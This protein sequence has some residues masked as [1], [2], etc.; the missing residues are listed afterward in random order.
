MKVNNLMHGLTRTIFPILLI[1]SLISCRK[2]RGNDTPDPA[3]Q[4]TFERLADIGSL[5]NSYSL[6]GGVYT[7]RFET[8]EIRIPAEEITQVQD[9]QDKWKTLVTL[10]GGKVVTVPTKGGNLDFMVEGVTLNPSGCNP[11]A[12]LAELRLPAAGRIRV[13]VAGKEGTSG[14]ITHLLQSTLVRQDVP[15]LGLYANY[16]NTITLTY[17]DKDG[18]ER[19]TTQLRIQTAPLPVQGFAIP[20]TIVAQTAKM[21]PGLNLVNYPGESEIDVSAPYMVDA[22]GEIRWILLLKNAPDFQRFG[23]SI[24]LKRTKKGTFISGDGQQHRIVEMD[25]F[26]KLLRKW[27]LAALGYTFHHEVAE[28]QNGNFLVTVSKS[29]ARLANGKPRINDFIIELDPVNGTIAH[30]WDLATML[31]TSRYP[32]LTDGSTPGPFAQSPGNWAHN[33]SVAEHLGNLLITCRYQGVFS[34]TAGG[35]LK[36]IIS[37]HKNW[38]D[39]FRRFLL[40]PVDEAGNAVTDVAVV[41]GAAAAPG[42]DWAWGPHTPVSLPNGNILVFDNGYDRQFT[43]NSQTQNYSRAVEYK[44]DEAKGTVQ[45][46][47]SYGKN[48]GAAAFS[49]ALSGVQYLKQTGHVMFFP[50][51]GVPTAKG[52]GGRVVEVDPATKEVIFEMEITAPSGTAFH[53]VTRLSLYPDTY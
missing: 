23:A 38:G 49:Q 8:E 11:L 7:F 14:T 13:T 33:N 52:F 18:K 22:E 12:A 20:Q 43:P 34:Y 32:K 24:G 46:V 44:I 6:S 50:G 28:A 19:G 21:E 9:Q 45:Q 4:K 25:M 26:G 47:W 39:K 53:R 51:M 42:F 5:L 15:I 3:I 35:S 27:D 29:S 10:R 48:R 41:N 37:P 16:N 36:W 1:A 30:E 40:K 17:T 2:N 31:D